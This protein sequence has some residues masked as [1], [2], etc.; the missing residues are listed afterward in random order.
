MTPE[1]K[2]VLD[3]KMRLVDTISKLNPADQKVINDQLVKVE[4][5]AVRA[6]EARKKIGQI[7]NTFQQQVKAL[8][9]RGY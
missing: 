4:A 5:A 1:E 3:A 2:A 8:F 7:L 9:A 6:E